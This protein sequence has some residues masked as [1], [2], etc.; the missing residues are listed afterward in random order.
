MKV[1]YITPGCF[2]KGGISR[3]CRYQISAIREIFGKENTYIM[4]LLGLEPDSIEESF[5][6]EYSGTGNGKLQQ[7]KFA[8]SFVWNALR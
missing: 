4:S 2:D 7:I 8:L 6:V 1:I 3:Y 5:E